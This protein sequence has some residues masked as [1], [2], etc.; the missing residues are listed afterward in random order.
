MAVA[1]NNIAIE[2]NNL[3]HLDTAIVYSTKAIQLNN[4]FGFA[5]YIR[6]ESFLFKG[7]TISLCNN[8]SKALKTGFNEAMPRIL[9]YCSKKQITMKQ[10]IFLLFAMVL[11]CTAIAY[12]QL[13][14][15]GISQNIGSFYYRDIEFNPNIPHACFLKDGKL[16]VGELDT[17][18]GGFL[19]RTNGCDYLVDSSAVIIKN[20]AE[21]GQVN[22][23]ECVFYTRYCKG[24]TC[25]AMSCF[26][27]KSDTVSYSLPKILQKEKTNTYAIIPKLINNDR[28]CYFFTDDMSSYI[29]CDTEED[30]LLFDFVYEYPEPK[31][32]ALKGP[33]WIPNSLKI[34]TSI[35]VNDICQIF[36]FDIASNK[37]K[38]VSFGDGNKY[39]AFFLESMD[40]STIVYL[41]NSKK[42]IVHN[43]EKSSKRCI[44]NT[45]QKGD[46]VLFDMEP[47]V[48]KNN[49]FIFFI[50]ETLQSS[51]VYVI[52]AKNDKAEPVLIVAEHNKIKGGEVFV[53]GNSVY[54]YYTSVSLDENTEHKY[55]LRCI[56]IKKML[57]GG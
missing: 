37:Y 5:Y 35:I 55:Q 13:G 51:S 21:W 16:Y 52:D 7:D 43:L 17:I 36:I 22:G 56:D 40:D 10:N 49:P 53:H 41:K 57:G 38:Q 48:F 34:L 11:F 54:F 12:V 29:S 32:K 50:E 4:N 30:T 47:F 23:E 19:N 27:P 14:K 9:K 33:R 8:L 15:A 1:E 44:Y 26:N 24:N 46:C 2:I 42:I 6:G 45:T 3:S 18:R 39:N 20:G 31:P 25:L 28:L